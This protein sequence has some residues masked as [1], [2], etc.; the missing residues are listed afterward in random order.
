[1]ALYTSGY[2]GSSSWGKYWFENAQK[3]PE[4]AFVPKKTLQKMFKYLKNVSLTAIKNFPCSIEIKFYYVNCID[5]DLPNR[6][7]LKP[8]MWIQK[9]PDLTLLMVQT[10]CEGKV[11]F[12]LRVKEMYGIYC[13]SRK[14]P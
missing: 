13:K 3:M 8:K 7:L 14:V 11:K 5:F 6:L 12:L 10:V 1:M 9:E 2:E 4:S